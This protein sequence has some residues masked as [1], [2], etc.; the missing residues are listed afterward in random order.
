VSNGRPSESTLVLSLTEASQPLSTPVTLQYLRWP[1]STFS[2]DVLLPQE[3][4][5]PKNSKTDS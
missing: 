2:L 5:N 4:T 1:A 3:T